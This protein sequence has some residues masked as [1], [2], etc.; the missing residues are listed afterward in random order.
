[1]ETIIQLLMDNFVFIAVILVVLVLI[2]VFVQ[3]ALAII[4]SIFVAA[5][6]FYAFTGDASFLNKTVDTS[7]MAVDTVKEEVGTVDFERTSDT[8]FILKTK[9]MK[10]E[11]D[12]ETRIATVTMGEKTFEVP[13][14]NIYNALDKATQE[15]INME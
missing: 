4:G 7:T 11:G 14:K 2:R 9:S 6:V 3:K 12:E 10:V 15:K 8:T 1:M 13:L 5:L